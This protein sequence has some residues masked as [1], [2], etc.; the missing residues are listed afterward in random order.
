MKAMVM[1]RVASLLEE[2]TPLRYV[3]IPIPSPKAGE[4]LLAVAACGVCHT[5][6][7]EIEGR[8]PPARLPTVLGHEVVGHVA[9]L[10]AGASRLS[11]GERVGVGWIHHSSGEHD[12][13]L[14]RQFVATGRDVNGGYAE[15][16]TVP[17]AYAYPIPDIF[18]DTEAAPLLC[19]GAIGYRALKL[20]GLADGAALGLTGFGGSAHLVLQLVQQLRPRSKVYVFA[21]DASARDFAR[22]LG[23]TWV[24]EA[25]ERA[26]VPLDAIIDT[27][28]AWKPVIEALANLR[29][30]GRLVINA[31]RKESTD[32]GE[33]LKLSY[34]AHLWMEREIK[35]VANI[36]RFDIIEFLPI[37]AKIPIRPSIQTY[38]LRDA[39]QALVDLKRKPV[40]GAKVLMIT[41]PSNPASA[42]VGPP[43]EA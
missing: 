24:G 21:R 15:Y 7:D 34:H 32:Q 3:D 25:N 35:T 6:I 36:T 37:A 31:I 2:Q 43:G 30:G 11:I 17:D 27:T 1:E 29:P 8:T 18:S 5:E 39:N 13:N 33:L 4:I 40:T 23:A 41:A 42:T 9:G 26:P 20:T 14:S 16:M 28:P 22:S 38:P 12:E 19:A 10:G